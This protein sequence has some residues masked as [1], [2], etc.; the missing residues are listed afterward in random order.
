MRSI[1]AVITKKLFQIKPYSWASGTIDEQRARQEKSTK[2]FKVPAGI[3]C[4]PVIVNGISSE[5]ITS[6]DAINGVILYLHGGAYAL[7]SVNVH[8]EYLSR[9]S[10]ATQLKILAINYRLA[11]EDPFPAA[12]EDS[13]AAFR[14]LLQQGFDP[15]QIVIA[16][17]SAGGGLTLAILVSLR[18]AG[19]PLPARAVCISPWLDLS[20][21]GDS[22]RE[23]AKSDPILNA[24]ILKKYAQYYSAGQEITSPLISPLFANF[25]GLPEILVLVGSDEILLDDSVRFSELAYKSGVEVTLKVWEGMFH[26]FQIISFLPEATEAIKQVAVFLSSIH[27]NTETK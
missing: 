24:T 4:Q 12:L 9:L 18:D 8:R 1:Q 20:L 22:V 11:P 14:W 3:R 2:F 10:L 13:I 19:D 26:V 23:K 21:S 15:S 25:H 7:G 5:W 16:G 17:D 6:S 27:R